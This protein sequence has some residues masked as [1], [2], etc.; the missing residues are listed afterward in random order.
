VWVCHEDLTPAGNRILMLVISGAW[1]TVGEPPWKLLDW[2]EILS[3][4][5]TKTTAPIARAAQTEVSISLVFIFAFG[6]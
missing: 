1:L 3:I 5:V 4:W 6:L 2:A